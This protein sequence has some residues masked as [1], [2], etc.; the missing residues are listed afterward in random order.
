MLAHFLWCVD[1]R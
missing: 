1:D